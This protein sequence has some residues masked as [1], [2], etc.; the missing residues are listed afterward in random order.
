MR[1]HAAP[2]QPPSTQNLQRL[3]D[4]LRRLPSECVEQVVGAMDLATFA[5]TLRAGGPLRRTMD[6]PMHHRA[7]LLRTDLAP[8]W[9]HASTPEQLRRRVHAEAGWQVAT[10]YRLHGGLVTL[11]PF[12]HGAN[13]LPHIARALS[14]PSGED[15][16]FFTADDYR[17]HLLR[18]GCGPAHPPSFAL[19]QQSAPTALAFA[20]P[21]RLFVGTASGPVA[22]YI[23]RTQRPQE[24][25]TLLGHLAPRQGGRA[26]ASH[27]LAAVAGGRGLV[28]LGAHGLLSWAIAEAEAEADGPEGYHGLQP[29]WTGA[30]AGAGTLRGLGTADDAALLATW[31][32]TGRVETFLVGEATVLATGPLGGRGTSTLPPACVRVVDAGR[33]LACLDGDRLLLYDSRRGWARPATALGPAPLAA[34]LGAAELLPH[35]GLW[36]LGGASGQLGTWDVRRPDAPRWQLRLCE[37]AVPLGNGMVHALAAAPDGRSLVAAAAYNAWRTRPP[38]SELTGLPLD[39]FG[40]A[41]GTRYYLVGHNE[42]HEHLQWL[43]QGDRVFVHGR[44]QMSVWRPEAP[45]V[46]PPQVEVDLRH[47]DAQRVLVGPATETESVRHS[48]ASVVRH[49][50]PR[51]DDGHGDAPPAD[52]TLQHGP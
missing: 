40:D 14:A 33:T 10:S 44:R 13:N 27:A 38:R 46:P 19:P 30:G 17:V 26:G 47:C 31:S 15:V 34:P 1:P 2:P 29:G 49:T 4:N 11:D 39:A 22:A 3:A 9:V 12:G 45:G 48:Y 23:L 43:P 5:A 32:D 42:R 20:G 41:V 37:P 36:A 35:S 7:A 6:Q 24:R 16:A 8:R 25:P 21:D 52:A 18:L 50:R 28:G 51:P